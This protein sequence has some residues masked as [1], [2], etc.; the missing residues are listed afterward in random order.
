MIPKQPLTPKIDSR[1]SYKISKL[2]NGLNA[3]PPK[4][5]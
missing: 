2:I 3:P 4:L 5:M 1:V